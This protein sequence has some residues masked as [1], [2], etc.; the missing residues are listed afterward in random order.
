MSFSRRGVDPESAQRI[1][2]IRIDDRLVAGKPVEIGPRRLERGVE[3]GQVQIAGQVQGR[4]QK[5]EGSGPGQ[6]DRVDVG[7]VIQQK[8]LSR[9]RTHAVGDHHDRQARMV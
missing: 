2:E 8:L 5:V 9:K 4:F 6:R 7:A 3:G 1:G